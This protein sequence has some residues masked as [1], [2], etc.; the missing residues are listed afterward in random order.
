MNIQD[1][2]T[3]ELIVGFL[4]DKLDR[5]G[6]KK[7]QQDL[8][9]IL[10]KKLHWKKPKPTVGEFNTFM[11]ANSHCK[12]TDFVESDTR[13]NAEK[14]INTLYR[15]YIG[16]TT[17]HLRSRTRRNRSELE[18]HRILAKFLETTSNCPQNP[19]DLFAQ[20]DQKMVDFIEK[21][22]DYIVER[23]WIIFWSFDQAGEDRIVAH[24][25]TFHRKYDNEKFSSALHAFDELLI[26]NFAQPFLK[27]LNQL[28]DDITTRVNNVKSAFEGSNDLTIS[29]PDLASEAFGIL[30]GDLV[31]GI[32]ALRTIVRQ[33]TRI[34]EIQS[35]THKE[36]ELLNGFGKEIKDR[37]SNGKNLS[38][39]KVKYENNIATLRNLQNSLRKLQKEAQQG[40]I[41]A[42]LEQFHSAIIELPI[43]L[44]EAKIWADR[45]MDIA[46]LTPESGGVALESAKDAIPHEHEVGTIVE[47][48]GLHK[49]YHPTASTVYA[50][51]GANLKI[52]KGEFVAVLGPSGSGKTTLINIMASLDIPNRG[53]VYFGGKDISLMSDN[54]LSD[55]FIFQQ[56]V[57][58]PRLSVYENV[59][60]PALIAGKTKNLNQRVH[61]LLESLGLSEYAN[62]DPTK[63]S[64]GQMQ[65]VIIARACINNPLVVFADE[66]TGDLDS[67]TGK[68]VLTNFRRLCDE[69]G[70][71]FIVVTHDQEM[72]AFADRIVRMKD[73]QMI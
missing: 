34:E 67:E 45:F 41:Q 33:I 2:W 71:A 23:S 29:D 56:Y 18:S 68:Q 8:Q 42:N 4:I 25:G 15:E 57:L 49:T 5:Y 32:D 1:S 36:I 58:D 9:K 22:I 12:N 52:Q 64:G 61:E 37:I 20:Q 13:A 30:V 19:E 66:P 62:Q 16:R 35:S 73:G 11:L 60:L 38:D 21:K 43:Q 54:E 40:K 59:A 7:L 27:S 51:R 72:A 44:R 28:L 48:I 65:R 31:G 10:K 14:P 70:I 63:L 17:K 47:A 39:L 69:K 26:L 3:G 50:L 6:N 24:D 55:F 53:K 46:F